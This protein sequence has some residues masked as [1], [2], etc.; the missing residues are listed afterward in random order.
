VIAETIAV[1]ADR[2]PYKAWS[3]A[4]VR[5]LGVGLVSTPSARAARGGALRGWRRV[6][7][8]LRPLLGVW[9]RPAATA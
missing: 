2:A 3:D 6:R 5:N 4:L 8:L 9:F 1:P 7:R